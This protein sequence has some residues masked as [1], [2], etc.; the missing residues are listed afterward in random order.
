MNNFVTTS[1]GQP[2][3]QQPQYVQSGQQSMDPAS[4][5][6]SSVPAVLNPEIQNMMQVYYAE[7]FN[8]LAKTEKELPEVTQIKRRCPHI[9]CENGQYAFAVKK[10]DGA[11][12]CNLCGREIN[13]QFDNTAIEKLNAAIAVID[14][15]VLF[16]PVNKLNGTPLRGLIDLKEGLAGAKKLMATL[17]QYVALESKTSDAVNNLG[18]GYRNILAGSNPITG[19]GNF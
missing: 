3:Y 9:S 10:V 4:K 7:K 12:K 2:I 8:P 17:N 18:D 6:D 19:M 1:Y 15:L 11:L 5:Y 14:Q 13:T 16:G